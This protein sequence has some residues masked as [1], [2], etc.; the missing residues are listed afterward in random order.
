M[1]ADAMRWPGDRNAE[2]GPVGA[3]SASL[4]LLIKPEPRHVLT[5]GS[6]SGSVDADATNDAAAVAP[7]RAR[8]A[9]TGERTA[10]SGTCAGVGAGAGAGAFLAPTSP[11]PSPAS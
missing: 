9:W 10:A 5:F 6:S 1:A 8:T 4:C 11:A 7:S 3:T 2:R